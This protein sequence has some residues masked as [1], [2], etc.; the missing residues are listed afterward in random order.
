MRTKTLLLAAAALAA[1]LVTSQAQVYSGVVGYVNVVL[2]AGQFVLVSNPLDDGTN[3]TTS[4]GQNLANKSSI[5]V[6]NG[7]GYTGANKA[8]GVWTPDLSIP[9][10]TG[11]FVNSKTTITNPFVGAVVA[12]FGGSATNVLPAG[13]LVL[14]GSALPFSGDLNDTNL[15]LGTTLANKSSIQV[16]NGNGFDGANKAGG[17]WTPN[18]TITNGEGVF[19][20]SKTTTN[21]VQTLPSN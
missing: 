15:N 10:G 1:G 12:P 6:W 13:V 7:S 11:F 14:V 9:V 5:Q 2:P 4:L 19:V 3:T 17:V 21:W 18:L 20:N 16:W 8:G